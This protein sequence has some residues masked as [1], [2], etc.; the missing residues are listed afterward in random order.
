MARGNAQEAATL[1][2]QHRSDKTKYHHSSKKFRPK[3]VWKLFGCISRSIFAYT[4]DYVR[5]K[6]DF[7]YFYV[8]SSNI[9]SFATKSWQW[10]RIKDAIDSYSITAWTQLCNLKRFKIYF[11]NKISSSPISH[12]LENW[13]WVGAKQN[14]N[15]E[16]SDVCG[17]LTSVGIANQLL[18]WQH[19]WVEQILTTSSSASPLQGDAHPKFSTQRIH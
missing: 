7:E 6:P 4:L 8:F 19:S 3:N 12:S 13:Q 10:A 17:C 1:K 14:W 5:T 18:W 16:I 15:S 2:R 11:H 9:F